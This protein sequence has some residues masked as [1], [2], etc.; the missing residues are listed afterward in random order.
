[1][2][3]DMVSLALFVR[4]VESNSLSKAAEQSH[5]ALAAASRRIAML[6]YRYG[7]QLLYRSSQ[8]VEPTPAGIALAEHARRMIEQAEKLQADL[9][10]YAKGV[11]GHIRIKANTSAITQFLPDDLAAFAINYPDVK[12]ELEESRSGEA[13]QALREGQADVGVVMDGVTLEGLESYEYRRD[14]LVAVVPRDHE[15]GADQCAFSELLK[16]DI[17]ALDSS[18][19]MMRLLA[20][21]AL[22]ANQPL[23]LRVQV[24]SFEAVCKLVQ[25]QMGIGVL[26]EIAAQQF[27][28]IMG[29]RLIRLTDEWADRTMHVC[30]RD[31]DS[32]SSIARKLVEQLVGSSR[33]RNRRSR[34]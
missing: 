14:R 2:L 10:D 31:Y 32:L 16:Y 13:A 18:A 30:V 34:S 27:V 29:L 17:V 25:A 33:L 5:I 19:A 28:P 3:P 12:F 21:A 6:E 20:A 1:M 15:V 11:K 8:G 7:V 22:D 26:P 9:S 23:R 24:R 4:A